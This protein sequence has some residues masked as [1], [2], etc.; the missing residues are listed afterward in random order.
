MSHAPM[1]QVMPRD[2]VRTE[3]EPASQLV[4]K[5]A[6]R[7][8]PQKR[9]EDERRAAEEN[10]RTAPWFDAAVAAYP[11]ADAYASAGS[12]QTGD[13]SEMRS[14]K[15]SV[16]LRRLLP[17][18]TH[19]PSALAFC[20]KYLADVDFSEH[21]DELLA[22]ASWL[23]ASIGCE[24]VPIKRLSRAELGE[25]LVEALD[26]GGVG[27]QMMET[28]AKRRGHDAVQVQLALRSEPPKTK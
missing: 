27:R 5:G 8:D 2:G 11:Y 9:L 7:A 18:L 12:M 20:E 13:L 3:C 23:L 1:R 21:P 26:D 15:R 17:T 10:A 28:A 16:A 22:F 24:A 4:R 14:G 19:A 25:L 6:K